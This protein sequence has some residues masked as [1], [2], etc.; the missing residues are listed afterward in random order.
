MSI[1]SL[2]IGWWFWSENP[3]GHW[4]SILFTGLIFAQLGL[5]L[6]VRSDHQPVWHHFFANRAMLGAV[7]LGAALH[8][9]IIYI[10]FLQEVFNTEPLSGP[11]LLL[12]VGGAAIV[13]LGVEVWKARVRR[14]LEHE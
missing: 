12:A 7:A 10:P 11:E 8:F 13:M 6:E 1:V 2:G 9:A 14:S 5:A 4:Q 3:D